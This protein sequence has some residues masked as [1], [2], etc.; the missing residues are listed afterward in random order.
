MDAP[1]CCACNAAV[2]PP[3]GRGRKLNIDFFA[4]AS[5]VL[6]TAFTPG[7]NNISSASMG[8]LFG[9]HRTLAYLAGIAIH[10][11]LHRPVMGNAFNIALAGLLVCTAAT[12]LPV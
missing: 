1:D 4:T 2:F 10:R 8:V 6:I 9:Y 12:C 7:P 3:V 5:F 11:Y